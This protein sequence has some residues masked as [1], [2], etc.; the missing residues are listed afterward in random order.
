MGSGQKAWAEEL[1]D[2]AWEQT[3]KK[4]KQYNENTVVNSIQRIK[5]NLE[6]FIQSDPSLTKTQWARLENCLDLCKKLV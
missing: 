3:L 1:E 5:E 2:E 4:F 6:R